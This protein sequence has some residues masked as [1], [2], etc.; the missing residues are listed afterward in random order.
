VQGGDAAVARGQPGCAERNQLRHAA[1]IEGA[2]TFNNKD[3]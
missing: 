3:V 2:L 1:S